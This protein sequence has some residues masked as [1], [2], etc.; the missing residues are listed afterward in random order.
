MVCNVVMRTWTDVKDDDVTSL[1]SCKAVE[2]SINVIF[3]HVMVI[4]K[5]YDSFVWM[6]THSPS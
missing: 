3:K 4:M 1:H 6:D 5:H 2:K